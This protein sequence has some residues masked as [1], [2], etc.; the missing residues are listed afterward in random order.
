MISFCRYYFDLII[1]LLFHFIA[2]N[3]QVEIQL[4][5]NIPMLVNMYA[6]NFSIR[7]VN[8]FFQ[9]IACVYWLAYINNQN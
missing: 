2:N 7:S 3:V 4:W 5:G 9:F 8:H 6:K 1:N